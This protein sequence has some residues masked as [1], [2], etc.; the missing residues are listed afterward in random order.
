MRTFND[1]KEEGF[2]KHRGVKEKILFP[3]CFLFLKK[4]FIVILA[5]FNLSSANGYLDFSHL[6]ELKKIHITEIFMK[7]Q[8]K[9]SVTKNHEIRNFLRFPLKG[10]VAS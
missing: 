5:M 2:G 3:L 8:Y 6:A 10:Y 1:L 4:S 9:S 7:K